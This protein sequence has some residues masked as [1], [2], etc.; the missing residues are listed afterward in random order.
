M[1]VECR[2]TTAY[3]WCP[4]DDVDALVEHRGGE[5]GRTR[6]GYTRELFKLL[7]TYFAIGGLVQS[8]VLIVID[9]LEEAIDDVAIEAVAFF[10]SCEP[11]EGV[12]VLFAVALASGEGPYIEMVR[13]AQHGNILP[14]VMT[15]D[16]KGLLLQPDGLHLST[17][18]Q[19][20]VGKMLAHAMLQ[21]FDPID[22]GDS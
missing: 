16:A 15:V 10:V 14:N 9:K 21:A 20:Q 8:V 11:R 19:V 1:G 12:L 2:A 7:T 4:E 18:A 22:L 6:T 13:K 3:R 17:S 5:R